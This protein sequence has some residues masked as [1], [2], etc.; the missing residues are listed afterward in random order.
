MDGF[1]G[2]GKAILEAL[3]RGFGSMREE[4]RELRHELHTGLAEVNARLDQTNARLDKVVENTGAHWRDHEQRIGRLE[5]QL[6]I[7]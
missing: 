6:G 5:K 4:M 2:S 3:E 7:E 1:N